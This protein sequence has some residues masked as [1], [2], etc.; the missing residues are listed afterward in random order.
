M[1]SLD[2]FSLFQT[3][4]SFIAS[5]SFTELSSDFPAA[6]IQMKNKRKWIKIMN[7]SSESHLKHDKVIE[8]HTDV[9]CKSNLS[10]SE[11]YHLSLMLYYHLHFDHV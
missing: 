8:L 10:S 5:V 4:Y 11:M 3:L 9:L 7:Q 6:K 2:H 1:F